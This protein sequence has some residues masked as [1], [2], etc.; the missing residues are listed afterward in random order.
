MFCTLLIV[1]LQRA[2]SKKRHRGGVASSA[3]DPFYKTGTLEDEQD[4]YDGSVHS[5]NQ[6]QS[7]DYDRIPNEY[8]G[9]PSQHLTDDQ[10]GP[11][12]TSDAARSHFEMEEARSQS[13]NN[14]YATVP[15]ASRHPSLSSAGQ[16]GIAPPTG[17]TQHANSTYPR[18][19]ISSSTV[20]GT[21][22]IRHRLVSAR[23]ETTPYAT[24]QQPSVPRGSSRT[25][26]NSYQLIALKENY[27]RN[28]TP[29]LEERA[30]IATELGM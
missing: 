29:S 22:P 2:S 13:D 17:H 30:V 11:Y 4:E 18:H 28:P 24:H 23:R 26:P 5:V 12:V 25:R 19:D 9:G 15:P 14:S 16:I 6:R 21:S 20:R 10:W 7:Q 8:R 1:H 3:L 27:A